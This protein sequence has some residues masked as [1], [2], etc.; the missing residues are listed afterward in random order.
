MP[1]QSSEDGPLGESTRL[2]FRH[3][4]I[5]GRERCRRMVCFQ[6][7][8]PVVNVD[9]CYVS[10]LFSFLTVI[11]PGEVTRGVVTVVDS[12]LYDLQDGLK[13][14]VHHG[15]SVAVHVVG[16]QF[17]MRLCDPAAPSHAFSMTGGSCLVRCTTVCS[18][19]TLHDFL[20]G[21]LSCVCH[22]TMYVCN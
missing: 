11:A 5:S 22:I 15:S 14:A 16:C 9:S 1:F 13:V 10:D 4:V 3:C 21:K 8:H 12:V 6:G 19:T 7:C 18:T 2:D 17:E 20:Y